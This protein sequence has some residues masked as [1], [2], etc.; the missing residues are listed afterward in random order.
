VEYRKSPIR[1][2]ASKTPVIRIG[3][4][5]DLKKVRNGVGSLFLAI[6]L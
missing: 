5:G 1:V 4:F 2:K 3:G 6:V